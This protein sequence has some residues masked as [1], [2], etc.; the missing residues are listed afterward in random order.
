MLLRGLLESTQVTSGWGLAARGTN[1]RGEGWTLR[2]RPD[3][4]AVSVTDVQ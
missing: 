1:R 3:P 2:P 4:R